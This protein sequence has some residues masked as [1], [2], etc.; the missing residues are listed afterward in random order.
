MLEYIYIYIY[1]IYL[2]CIYFTVPLQSLSCHSL[3]PPWLQH[4]MEGEKISGTR[5]RLVELLGVGIYETFILP[6]DG[7]WL[8]RTGDVVKISHLRN[9]KNRSMFNRIVEIGKESAQKRLWTVSLFRSC[10]TYILTEKRLLIPITP[11][12]TIEDW[13]EGQSKKLHRLVRRAA[14]NTWQEARFSKKAAM[15]QLETQPVQ[16]GEMATA[17]DR[18]LN[19]SISKS[20]HHKIVPHISTLSKPD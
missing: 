8:R 3:I 20:H 2:Y 6:D 14:K 11:Q 1:I 15:D 18:F 9:P 5:S 10:L 17:Q 13:V 16:P 4:S 19:L 12:F 7:E